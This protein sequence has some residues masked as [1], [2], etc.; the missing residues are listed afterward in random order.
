M[1]NLEM[2]LTYLKKGISVMPL[3]SPEMVK[4]NPSKGFLK[5]LEEKMK[6]NSESE[7]PI[8][9]EEIYRKLFIDQC[10]SPVLF[11]WKEYRKR[12]PSVEE[13]TQW[14]TENPSANIAI[15]TG[16]VSNIVVFDLDSEE[17]ENFAQGRGG[18]PVTVRVKTGKGHHVYMKHPGIETNNRINRKLKIDIKADGGYVVAPPSIHGSG[19]L[20][21]WEEDFSIFDLEPSECTPWMLEHLQG[22]TAEPL[23]KKDNEASKDMFE[24][25]RKRTDKKESESPYVEILK[26]GCFEGERNHTATRL[27]GHL[28]KMGMDQ[29]EAWEVITMWNLKNKPPLGLN[30]LRKTF[31]SVK[32]MES[33][34]DHRSIIEIGSLLDNPQKVVQEYEQNYVRIP[35]GG[36]NLT[37]LEKRMNGGLI[38]GRV[39]GLGGIPSAGKTGLGNNITDNICLN[40]IPVLFFSYDDG[41][42]DL[43]YRT[44]ARFCEESIERFNVNCQTGIKDLCN[45]PEI[46]KIM[47]LKYVVEKMIYLDEWDHYI[48]KIKEKHGQAPVIIVDYLQKIRIPRKFQDERLRIEEIVGQ[49]TNLA[50]SWNIPIVA[51][52]ELARDSYK[53]GQKLSMA[54]FKE[55]GMIEYESSWLGILAPVEETEDGYQVKQDWEKIIRHDG[56]ID[57][58]VFKAKRGT[59]FTGKIPLKV[60]KEHMTVTDR[61]DESGKPRSKKSKFE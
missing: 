56:T 47:T 23:E 50:K 61:I 11:E 29:I 30:E 9:K 21:Q 33:K 7:N 48:S 35:F 14:F 58:I 53:S 38:G 8:S 12:L 10:K 34:N 4:K 13:V 42:I 45:I 55:T 43:R 25:Q 28:F 26:K 44:F 5:T 1:N 36:T 39:Y 6:E 16:K 54:S 2:A 46:K 17:A 49:L 3:W 40:G 27:T 52:S 15:I 60:D 57:L 32:A 41:R 51:I 18:F 22:I 19:S 20:Y 24:N 37:S 59:G 31:Q